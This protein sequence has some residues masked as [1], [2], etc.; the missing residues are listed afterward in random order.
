MYIMYC[1]FPLSSF[2]HSWEIYGLCVQSI[3]MYTYGTHKPYISMNG[4][5]NVQTQQKST[6]YFVGKTRAYT[7]SLGSLSSSRV[8]CLSV[9]FACTRMMMLHCLQD[10]AVRNRENWTP[11]WT[12]LSW[13]TEVSTSQMPAPDHA[14][15]QAEPPLMARGHTPL[16]NMPAPCR[17]S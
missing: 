15:S 7:T 6:V 4:K 17:R 13:N 5:R 10:R 8:S 12:P 16:S 1:L 14:H 11:S 3:S 2:K 9:C